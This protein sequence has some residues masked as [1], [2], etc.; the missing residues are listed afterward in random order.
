MDADWQI[1]DLSQDSNALLLPRRFIGRVEAGGHSQDGEFGV[2]SGVCNHAGGPLGSGT[3]EGD[4]VK[5][6]WHNWKYHRCTGLANRDL[7][8][9]PRPRTR[10][11]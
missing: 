11:G 9:T 2:I 7:K 4:Y 3:L 10:C 8:M 6:P 5:C 1:S